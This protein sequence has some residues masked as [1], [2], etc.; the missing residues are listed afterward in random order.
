MQG[1]KDAVIDAIK[2]ILGNSFVLKTTIVKDVLTKEQ[3]TQ[4]IEIVYSGIMT[5]AIEYAPG[6]SDA[7][8]V[9]RYTR[10]MV[11]NHLRKSVDL[12]GGVP[13]TPSKKGNKRDP[14]IKEMTKLLATVPVGSQQARDIEKAIELRRQHINKNKVSTDLSK[15]INGIN[16]DV[17]PPSLATIVNETKESLESNM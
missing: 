13:Y 11:D 3:K 12:T 10:S 1:Q 15:A 6:T 2:S 9:K 8:K 5:G 7:K 16:V 4:L 17:L 14:K